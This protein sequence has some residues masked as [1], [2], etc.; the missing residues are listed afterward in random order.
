MVVGCFAGLL[1]PDGVWETV[2]FLFVGVVA[3]LFIQYVLAMNSSVVAE[4]DDK[5]NK[6]L[7]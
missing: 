3:L 5:G 1:T 6:R 2:T 7:E 4:P